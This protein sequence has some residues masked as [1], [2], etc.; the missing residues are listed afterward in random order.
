VFLKILR[1]MGAYQ[2]LELE[3]NKSFTLYKQYLLSLSLSLY[4]CVISACMVPLDEI[5]HWDSIALDLVKNA[6]DPTQRADAAA[7][8]MSEGTSSQALPLLP[9]HML[10]VCYRPRELVPHHWHDDDR[11]LAH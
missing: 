10:M 9:P 1:Q 8:I 3:I 6:T 2:S 4:V 5:R 11:Q 7:V